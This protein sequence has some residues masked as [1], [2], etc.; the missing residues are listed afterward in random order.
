MRTIS[1]DG[2]ELVPATIDEFFFYF[3]LYIF[4]IMSQVGNLGSATDIHMVTDH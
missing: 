3:D 4:V 2:S 1:D